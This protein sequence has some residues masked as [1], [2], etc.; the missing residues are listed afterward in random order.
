M[1]EL[2][3]DDCSHCACQTA[4]Q[5]YSLE[6]AIEELESGQLGCWNCLDQQEVDADGHYACVV[7]YDDGKIV[8]DGRCDK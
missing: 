6:R 7:L 1:A 2:I 5:G 4:L 3:L 8:W